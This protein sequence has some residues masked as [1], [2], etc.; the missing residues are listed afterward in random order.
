MELGEGGKG[1][2]KAIEN[3][4]WEVKGH[5]SS[6]EWVKWTKVKHTHSGDT[7][8]NLFEYQLKH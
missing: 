7:L 4:R 2:E 1:K 6:M 8:R 3:G 5:R